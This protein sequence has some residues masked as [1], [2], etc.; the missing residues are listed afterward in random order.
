MEINLLL[1]GDKGVGKTAFINRH[2]TDKFISD[3]IHTVG[4]TRYVLEYNT[5]YGKCKINISE[6][7]SEME[8]KENY[9]SNKF[10]GCIIMFDVTSMESYKN[11]YYWYNCLLKDI[12]ITLCGNKIDK[13][14]RNV[15]FKDIKF[16]LNR[17]IDYFDI[18]VKSKYQFEKPFINIIQKITNH[19]DLSFDKFLTFYINPLLEPLHI[20]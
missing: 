8:I 15:K 20:N 16:H 2:S 17:N 12:Q 19:N 4:S 3:Y 11:V 10:D 6:C 5:N 9:I 13:K 7:S 1:I 14:N 18:S